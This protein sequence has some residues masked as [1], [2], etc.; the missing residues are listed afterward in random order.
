MRCS[1]QGIPAAQVFINCC[2]NN[3]GGG[4][5]GDICESIL[6]I[7]KSRLLTLQCMIKGHSN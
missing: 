7:D 1:A 2:S 6:C 5:V 4:E 3:L